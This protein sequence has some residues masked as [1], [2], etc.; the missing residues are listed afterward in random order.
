MHAFGKRNGREHKLTSVVKNTQL[1]H[2]LCICLYREAK[3][4]KIVEVIECISIQNQ[5]AIVMEFM[6]GGN[7]KTL[8]EKHQDGGQGKEFTVRFTEDIGSALEH[9]HSMNIIHRDVKPENIFVRMLN[10]SAACFYLFSHLHRRVHQV[11]KQWHKNSKLLYGL[12]KDTV[13]LVL[14]AR[15][16]VKLSRD[17][18]LCL[19]NLLK[20]LQ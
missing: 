7:L 6:A 2:I 9:L 17:Y 4:P 15:S 18:P 13:I 5:L 8:L 12:S 19:I 16:S 10:F 1:F 3:H 20:K 11:Q 14:V